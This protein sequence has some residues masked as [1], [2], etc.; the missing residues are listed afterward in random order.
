MQLHWIGSRGG[1]LVCAS[2]GVAQFW[3]GVQGSSVCDIR[4]DYERACDLIDYADVIECASSQVLV[5]GDEP[6][7]SA[8]VLRDKAILVVRWVS[9][10]SI[11][12]A[13][14]AISLLPSVLPNIEE[15]KNFRLDGQGLILFDSAL[16]GIDSDPYPS[17]GQD[18]EPGLFKVTTERYRS[19]HAY[20]FI[21]HRLLRH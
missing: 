20:E 4:S 16:A 12:E 6:L 8:L 5:L 2:P 11:E 15:T 9:C 21:V 3:L 10:V 13:E 14:R 19:D 7:Q 18:L 17:I 1:P